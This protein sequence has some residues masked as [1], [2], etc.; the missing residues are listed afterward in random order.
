LGANK[1]GGEYA[2][3]YVIQIKNDKRNNCEA[4]ANDTIDAQ[5]VVVIWE[6]NG[7]KSIVSSRNSAQRTGQ[8]GFCRDST[9][10]SWNGVK[11]TI[12]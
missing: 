5:I 9:P 4:F 11:Q 8:H 10:P 6:G 3:S 2:K 7:G 1:T 12:H